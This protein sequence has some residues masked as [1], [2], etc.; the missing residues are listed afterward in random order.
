[1]SRSDVLP[2]LFLERLARI[3]PVDRLDAVRSGFSAP[4]HGAGRVNRLR[5]DPDRVLAELEAGGMHPRPLSW[6]GDGF[7]VDPDERDLLGRSAAAAEARVWLQNPASMVPPLGLEPSPGERVLDLAAAPGSK[8]LQI[9]GLMEG[10]GELAAVEVVRDRFFRLRRNLEAGGAG[11]ARTFLKDGARVWRHRPDWFDRVLVDAPC[12]TEGR[13]REDEPE[14][15]AY[16]SP[17]KIRGMVRRQ[18]PLLQGALRAVRSGGIVVYSTCTFAP[19]ENELVIERILDW[20]AGSVETEPLPD[21]LPDLADALAVWEGRDLDP[22]V[23][24]ARRIIPDGVFEAFFVCRLRRT[25]P[26][27]G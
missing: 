2:A 11:F 18:V 22:R 5:A 4:R 26:L 15:F 24:N 12:T 21:G 23:A 27:D 6:Y 10:E 9:A 19:E 20:G 8:T 1:M 13:F 7:V 14:T 17:R 25:G 16:W 3:V